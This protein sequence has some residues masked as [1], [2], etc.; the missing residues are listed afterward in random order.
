MSLRIRWSQ[1]GAVL[2][3]GALA[4]L[5]LRVAPSL[6][7]PPAAAPVPADVG[8]PR[9]TMVP[10][11]KP[12]RRPERDSAQRARHLGRMVSGGG[13]RRRADASQGKTPARRAQ[14]PAVRRSAQRMPS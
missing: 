6:L 5:A 8:L 10:P 2:L 3:L 12:T 7:K 14:G 11:P 9:V 1:A 13:A 4:L